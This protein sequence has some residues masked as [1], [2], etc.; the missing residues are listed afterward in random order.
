MHLLLSFWIRGES[1]GMLK[2]KR[3]CCIF[4]KEEDTKEHLGYNKNIDARCRSY[5]IKVKSIELIIKYK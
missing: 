1:A 3:L 5:N 2:N 4:V